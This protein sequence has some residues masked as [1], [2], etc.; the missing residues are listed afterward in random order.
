MVDPNS[1]APVAV[2]TRFVLVIAALVA[3]GGVFL[4]IRSIVVTTRPR[5]AR[6]SRL[7]RILKGGGAHV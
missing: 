6:N 1:Y 5:H 4:T 3:A 2:A 7:S